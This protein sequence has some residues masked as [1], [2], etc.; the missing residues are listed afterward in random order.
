M[1]PIKPEHLLL[2]G[3]MGLGLYA[4]VRNHPSAAARENAAR[5]A[6]AA[7]AAVGQAAKNVKGSGPKV[8][9]A[10]LSAGIQAGCVG[11]MAASGVGIPFMP[12][13]AVAGAVM[14]GVL[15]PLGKFAFKGGKTVG[16]RSVKI[17]K[18]A[19]KGIKKVG[20]FL[21]IGDL[22]DE[23]TSY[24]ALSAYARRPVV[25]DGAGCCG[26]PECDC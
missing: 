12:L 13:C 18:G 2:A 14:P 5:E 20:K 4:L 16:K 8:G 7:R 24:A 3:G 21:G 25:I 22:D 1:K 19:G 17:V 15:K 10:L 23:L 11:G 6:A 26:T 9:D